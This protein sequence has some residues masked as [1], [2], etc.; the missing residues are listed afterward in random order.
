MYQTLASLVTYE[1]ANGKDPLSRCKM[2]QMFRIGEHWLTLP[3]FDLVFEFILYEINVYKCQSEVSRNS[4]LTDTFMFNYWPSCFG[5]FFNGL[6]FFFLI[7]GA[8]NICGR[9]LAGLLVSFRV[10]PFHLNNISL[11]LVGLS[12]LLT[13]IYQEFWTLCLFSAFYGFFL[14]MF[15]YTI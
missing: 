2:P 9:C 5:F 13:P 10:D 8:M 1:V 15:H 12:C 11:L 14:G 4:S 7:L 3:F 6:H